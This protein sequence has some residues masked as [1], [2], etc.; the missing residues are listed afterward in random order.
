MLATASDLNDTRLFRILAVLAAIL[1]AF[2]ARTIACRVSAL[3]FI[4]VL[5]HELL[6]D[7]L[8]VLLSSNPR[9]VEFRRQATT[10]RAHF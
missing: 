9:T 7:P 6:L 10:F 8:V 5:S 1:A 2:F 3:V 4:L